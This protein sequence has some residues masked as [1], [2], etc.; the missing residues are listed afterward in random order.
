MLGEPESADQLPQCDEVKTVADSV[1]AGMTAAE[2]LYHP[3]LTNE[4]RFG[5]KLH[6][7]ALWDAML[8]AFKVRRI[9]HPPKGFAVRPRR[10][11]LDFGWGAGAVGPRC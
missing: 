3:D 1:V 8:G 5:K 4:Q 2:K 6:G 10:E 11:E 7:K 9:Q